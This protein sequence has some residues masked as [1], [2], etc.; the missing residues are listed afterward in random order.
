MAKAKVTVVSVKTRTKVSKPTKTTSKAAGNS[1]GNQK[2][3]PT[4]GRYL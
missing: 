3:C 2:R 1:K 4:C